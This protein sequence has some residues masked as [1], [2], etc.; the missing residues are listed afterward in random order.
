MHGQPGLSGWPLPLITPL[1]SWG[2]SSAAGELH[3]S[4]QFGDVDFYIPGAG[5]KTTIIKST[6]YNGVNDLTASH[7]L[8]TV[9]GLRMY[10]G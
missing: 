3:P 2:G 8:T 7:S 4:G 1:S 6:L 9:E 10:D 5:L